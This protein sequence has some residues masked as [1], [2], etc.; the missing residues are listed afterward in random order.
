MEKD[1]RR[2]AELLN[3]RGSSRDPVPPG[4]RVR[5]GTVTAASASDVEAGVCTITLGGDTTTPIVGVACL[6]SYRP[7]VDDTVWV[8]VNGTDLLV[9][10]RLGWDGSRPFATAAGTQTV[11]VSAATSGTVTGIAL[12][13]GRF[14]VAPRIVVS[15]VGTTV[16][17]GSASAVTAS[18]FNL[19][20]RHIDNTSATASP[21]MH[22]HAIQ[23]TPTS[24]DG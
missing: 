8:L 22:W 19:T 7:V 2:A 17:V 12:P 4:L 9:L 5:A 11:S 10:G 24:A 23:M 14:T 3:P 1:W 20:A 16:Y 6:A 21:V 18:D 15:G 13:A